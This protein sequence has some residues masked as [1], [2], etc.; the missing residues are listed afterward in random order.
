M[1]V[2]FYTVL[3]LVGIFSVI[4][5]LGG[6][7]LHVISGG[8]RNYP[9]RKW[10]AMFHGI[11]LLLSLIG[12]F[13]LLAK[14]GYL[15]GLPGW[16]VAKLVIWLILGGLPALIYRQPKLAKLFWVLILAFGGMAAWLATY[17]PF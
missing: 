8:T 16:A 14:L 17:K 12:G 4:L 1:S 2:E 7:C 5:S 9:G 15:H 6:M 13:G 3:H 11:G 10:S